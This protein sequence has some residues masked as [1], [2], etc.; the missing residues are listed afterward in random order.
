MH[1]TNIYLTEEQ[2]RALDQRARRAGTTRSAVVRDILDRDLNGAPAIDPEVAAVF[3][4][5]YDRYDEVVGDLFDDDPDL[6]IER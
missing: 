6:R 3:G 4:E 5:L 2:E 1:R